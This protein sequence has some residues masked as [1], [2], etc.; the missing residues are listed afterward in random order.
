M[1]GLDFD[2][3]TG[4]KYKTDAETIRSALTSAKKRK[5]MD[6]VGNKCEIRGCKLKAQEVHHIKL[7]SKGGTNVGSNLIVLCGYHHNEVH[8]GAITQTIIEGDCKKT[9]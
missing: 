7:V 4:D 2:P 8:S 1:F 3:I 6:A 5:I 9:N